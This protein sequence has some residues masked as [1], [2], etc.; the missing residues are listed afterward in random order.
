MLFSFRQTLAVLLGICAS[1]ILAATTVHDETFVPDVILRVT[2]H[3]V[4][5]SCMPAKHVVLINGT[6][7]GP[8]LRLLEDRTYWIRV[9]ND[10]PDANLTMVRVISTPL[11]EKI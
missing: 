1:G 2:A 7:P 10:M 3:D 5:Q 6:S 9:Y 4:V 8:E 11:E